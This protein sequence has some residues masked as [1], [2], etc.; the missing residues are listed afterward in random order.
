M[1][2]NKIIGFAV[3]SF[4][5]V[6]S[7]S[8]A[9]ALYIR[10]AN[11]VTMGISQGQYVGS[12]GEITYT[13]NGNTAGNLQPSYLKSDGTNGGTGLGP[14]TLVGAEDQEY[15]TQVKYE[16][17]LGAN[18]ADDLTV[19]QQIVGNVSVSITNI[20]AA[21]QGNLSIWV[22]MEGY[23]ENSQ[24]KDEFQTAFMQSDYA[25]TSEHPSYT[26]SADVA[27]KSSSVQKVAIYL[28]YSTAY[29]SDLYAQDE[30]LLGYTLSVT[31][32]EASNDYKFAYVVG[33]HTQWSDDE[34]FRMAPE[35]DRTESGYRWVYNNLPGSFGQAKCHGGELVAWSAGDNATLSSG[36]N[37]NV[38]WSG[39]GNDN[40]TFTPVA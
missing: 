12:N 4:G 30:A 5:A 33:D 9:A 2:K 3:A 28:K 16:A 17:T 21:A 35:I 7:I 24:G 11:N 14:V 27:V 26:G 23:L 39:N 6:A 25:I 8:L 18:F 1:K 34:E 29:V 22:C 38:Y 19:Q 32:G 37:Y 15:Y 13:I 31:W 40:A 36:T 10:A 20:P